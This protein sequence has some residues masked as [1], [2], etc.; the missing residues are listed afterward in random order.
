VTFRDIQDSRD[1]DESDSD[2]E[3][4]ND[5]VDTVTSKGAV[6]G[7]AIYGGNITRYRARTIQQ[8]RRC[9]VP[10]DLEESEDED[11][12]KCNVCCKIF[13]LEMYLKEH[14]C[15]G[16]IASQHLMQF[17]LYYAH[18]RVDQHHI[19]VVMVSDYESALKML[20][21][22]L[23]SYPQIST[24]EPGWVITPKHGHMY[25]QR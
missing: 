11:P 9:I 1:R 8:N 7:C 18:E 2:N 5:E 12:T 25:G 24:F 15:K 23:Q 13:M 6:T 19:D 3:P 16:F 10:E 4:N 17:A 22:A 14:I 20:E 21:D